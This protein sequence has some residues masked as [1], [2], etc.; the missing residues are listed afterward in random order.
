MATTASIQ[1]DGWTDGWKQGLNVNSNIK[2]REKGTPFSING[3]T[4]ATLHS[5][6]VA[7][8]SNVDGSSLLLLS[9]SN[10]NIRLTLRDDNKIRTERER[11]EGEKRKT[12]RK[13]LLDVG[14]VWHEMSL[15]LSLF[16][17]I[18]LHEAIK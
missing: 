6:R 8:I 14:D 11:R 1:T 16:H 15:S 7:I 3:F 13:H 2:R 9:L 18:T 4:T 17:L 12:Q 10:D 5:H